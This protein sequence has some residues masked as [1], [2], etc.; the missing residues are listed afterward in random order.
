MQHHTI[1]TISTTK[2]IQK[3]EYKKEKRKKLKYKYAKESFQKCL[4]MSSTKIISV[5]KFYKVI[6]VTKKPTQNTETKKENRKP[7]Q[8]IELFR[9]V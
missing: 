9:N 7:E 2:T 3:Q 1:N 4:E 8:Y 5:T 6:M